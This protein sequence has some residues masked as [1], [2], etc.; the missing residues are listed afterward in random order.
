[1]GGVRLDRPRA[2]VLRRREFKRKFARNMRNSPTRA[3]R[4]L[5][6]LLRNKQI[7]ALRFRRQQPIGPYIVDFFCPTAK[8]IVELDGEQHGIDANMEHDELRSRNL[9]DR[10][11]RVLRFSNAQL[12]NHPEDVLEGILM[13]LKTCGRPLPE[14]LRGSTLPQGES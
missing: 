2:N 7:I 4:K 13:A 8:V 5:W 9:S 11:Y 10:G 3:E 12:L 14:P 6:S 1:R